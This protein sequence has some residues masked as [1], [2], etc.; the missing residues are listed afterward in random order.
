MRISKEAIDAIKEFE[1]CELE[2]YRDSGGVWTIGIGHTK[3]VTAGQEITQEQAEMLFRNDVMTFEKAVIALYPKA[4]QHEFDALV[5]LV[6][7]A[8]IGAAGG[9]LST[10]IKRG[11]SKDVIQKWWKSHYIT[12]K[13]KKL[14][15][16][17]RRREWEAEWYFK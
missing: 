14:K 12:C 3:G 6:Y 13:G 17:V 4:K 5:S 11:S 7:N 8:G 15:G 2:S 10:L 9:T 16:L 1:G